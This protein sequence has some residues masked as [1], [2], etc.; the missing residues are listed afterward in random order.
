MHAAKRRQLPDPSSLADQVLNRHTALLDVPTSEVKRD[1]GQTIPR[2]PPVSNPSWMEGLNY[3]TFGGLILALRKRLGLTQAALAA[4]IGVARSTI[5]SIE[6]GTDL[7]G[8][9]TLTAFADFF[10][11]PL[12]Q[13][14]VRSV[15]PRLPRSGEIIE[16]LDE[17]AVLNLWR[18]LT[19]EQRDLF[20]HMIY[21]PHH[22]DAPQD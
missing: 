1:V 8:R 4:E 9:E 21:V 13:L 12:D 14:R 22:K 5:A 15:S 2:I 16:D 3:R 11:V 6:N 17:L 10:Q 18:R 20:K 7:P 19:P